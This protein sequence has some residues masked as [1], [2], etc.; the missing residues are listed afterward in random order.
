MVGKG[1]GEIAQPPWL[2]GGGVGCIGIQVAVKMLSLCIRA[3][4][5]L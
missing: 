4:A 2:A 5:E 3:V 1:V